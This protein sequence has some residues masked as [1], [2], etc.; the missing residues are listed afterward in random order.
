MWSQI[1]HRAAKL[2]FSLTVCTASACAALGGSTV[3]SSVP[4]RIGM[5]TSLTG[6]Y[7]AVGTSD[8]L[9][10]QQVVDTTNANNGINGRKLEL[11]IVDDGSN[12]TQSVTQF[13]TMATKP[14]DNPVVAILGP[15]QAA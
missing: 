6:N 2:V 15:P 5:V 9:A 1:A 3:E 13:E 4:I 10:A 7:A 8:R 11:D 12:P 14:E